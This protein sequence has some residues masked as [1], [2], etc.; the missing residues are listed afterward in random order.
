MKHLVISFLLIIA[1]TTAATAQMNVGSNTAPDSSAMLQIS[2]NTKGFLPP[3][4][5]RDSMYLIANPARGL[6]VFNTTD[7]MLY[8][9]RDSGWMALSAGEQQ[10]LK[11][12]NN[13]YNTNSGNVG[14]GTTVPASLVHINGSN[15][16]TITGLTAGTNTA[17]DSVLTISNGV[18]KKLPNS[19]FAN[20]SN[21]ITSLNGLTGTTQTFAT[22][23]IGTD[24]NIASSGTTHTFNIPDASATSRGLITTTGT[25]IIA[26]TKNFSAAPI[27]SALT[28]GSIP[29]ITST[30]L[31]SQMNSELFWDDSNRRLGIGTNTPAVKLDVNGDI[32]GRA[33]IYADG[34]GANNGAIS[35]GILFGGSS[36]EGISSRRT[37]TAVGNPFGLDFYTSSKNR[38]AI[39][40]A[41]NV[42]IG[43]I[44]PMAALH[45]VAATNTNP[46]ILTGVQPG[47]NTATD[48]VLIINNGV[49]R[50][51]P[52]STFANTANAISKLNGL[53]GTTQT[54]A[55]GNTG[56]DFNIAS[57]GTT[58][59]FN[60]PD[61]SATTRG[62]ITTGDQTIAGVKSFSSSPALPALL[63]GS[64][65]F[66]ASNTRL[67][68]DNGEFFWDAAIKRLGIGTNGP[69]AKLDVRGDIR[70]TGPIS[71]T[72]SVVVNNNNSN[73]GALNPGLVFG[74][75]NST[76]G[77]S[78]KR[79]AG[80]NQGGLDFYTSNTNR[81][82]ITKGGNVGIGTNAPAAKL[83]VNGDI[84]G[85][86]SIYVDEAGVNTGT[87][88]PALLFGAVG[89]GESIASQRT[90]GTNQYG[91]DF[92]AGNINRI[93]ILNGGNVGIGTTT[94]A[95]KLTVSGIV[96]PEFDNR[97]DLG[98]S[99]TRWATVYASNGVVQTSDRRLKT[100][101][102]PLSYGLP[103]VM[104][105]QPVSYNW[106]DAAHKE[107]KIG[108]IAQDVKNIVPEVVVGDEAKEN[109]GMNYAEL[110]P[111]LINA[112]RQQ[113]E[114]IESLKKDVQVLKGNK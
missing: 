73:P 43:T 83:D 13:I 67:N 63:P 50:K 91:M 85:Q 64:I 94:P 27:L 19:T 9:H 109:L 14:I 102:K 86:A 106:K 96:A 35:P 76:E 37:F 8:L 75:P 21:A 15:P 40:N 33:S 98:A 97:F 56:T 10:W 69:A 57:S 23:N 95:Y 46:L 16:L 6:I 82:A 41:G 1:L 74:D 114:E 100:N 65:L 104:K 38:M 7:S 80:G 92:Y 22:G 29:Y 51:L 61:A 101:I 62:V 20:T 84:F 42:G 4:M 68:Q 36:S 70:T 71:T 59:T 89:T 39:T 28:P 58:H 44:V 18:V 107:N 17:T 60:I 49:V 2:G 5:N 24:F 111:V 52:N 30:K 81:M 66:L 110:V 48:S 99:G 53:T 25:Q 108:L 87:K 72:S 32:L 112:I 11:S 12:G 45:V 47:T 78:S 26:G 31:L 90:A 54:F 79:N 77:I 88:F 55:T 103:E 93:A 113:Q 105:M 3:R 34:A